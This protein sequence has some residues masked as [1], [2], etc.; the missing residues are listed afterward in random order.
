M[1][2]Q[3]KKECLDANVESLDLIPAMFTQISMNDI[4][5][6][7]E[8]TEISIS[9]TQILNADHIIYHIQLKSRNK[10]ENHSNWTV[11]K[12]YLD[13]AEF[14]QQ[15]TNIVRSSHPQA[16][17]LIP[18]FPRKHWKVFTDHFD[19][20]FVEKRRLLLQNYFRHLLKHKLFRKL[21]VT[22]MF[23]QVTAI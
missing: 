7:D 18:M 1:N 2:R 9:N 17:E 11:L 12:R 5:D 4:D 8:I 22:L 14:H 16:V 13:M 21:D 10:D 19:Y 23:F 15:L 3:Q 6:T 20:T